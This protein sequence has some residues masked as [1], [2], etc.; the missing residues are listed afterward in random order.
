MSISTRYLRS[1]NLCVVFFDVVNYMLQVQCQLLSTKRPYCDFVLWTEKEVHVERIYPDEE[2]WL[3][4]L[5]LVKEVYTTAILPELLRKFYTRPRPSHIQTLQIQLPMS[6][7][8]TTEVYCYCQGPEEGQMVGCDNTQCKY[9][10]FHLACLGLKSEPKSK[11]WYCPDC[12]QL[13]EFQNRKGKK[14]KC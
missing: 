10:W 7:E 13:P 5:D 1:N 11:H 12:R 14:V 3:K 8:G 2:S 6:T 9:Q 4:N